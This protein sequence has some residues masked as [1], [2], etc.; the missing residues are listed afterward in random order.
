MKPMRT[1]S[2]IILLIVGTTACE[3]EQ[4]LPDSATAEQ[5]GILK[6][7]ASKNKSGHKATGS[8]ELIWKGATKGSDKGNKPDDLQ[9]FF[10]FNAHEGKSGNAPKGELVYRVLEADASLHREIKAEVYDVSFDMEKKRALIHAMVFS[11]SK[12]CSGDDNGGHDSNCSSGEHDDSEGGC[13]HD[14]LGGDDPT[15]DEGGCSHDDTGGDDPTHEEGGCSQDDTDGDDVIHDEGCSGEDDHGGGMGGSP[16]GADKGNPTSGKN[17]RLG[18]TIALKVRD[19]GT[20][21]SEGDLIFWKW[22]SPDATNL[23]PI[24]DCTQ[25]KHLCEKTI[26]EGNIVVHD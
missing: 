23:P 19:L 10:E 8:V 6:G 17:C 13:S 21:G 18:Q 20:P 15:H 7:A 24:S 14:D 22:F 1:L 9:V 4:I 5:S 16:G 12:G 25:W 2:A 11:D 3:K 26:I